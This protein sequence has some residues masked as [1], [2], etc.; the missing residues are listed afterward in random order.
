[1]FFGCVMCS[2]VIPDV[3]ISSVC[4]QSNIKNMH[5][6]NFCKFVADQLHDELSSGKFNTAWL[7][8]LPVHIFIFCVF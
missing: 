2:F 3:Y 7:F 6:M 8:L 1:M 4:F 5:N